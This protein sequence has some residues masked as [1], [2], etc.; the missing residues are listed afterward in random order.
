[1]KS[2]KEIMEDI[3]V[4]DKVWFRERPHAGFDIYG[5]VTGTTGDCYLVRG[6]SQYFHEDNNWIVPKR[7][8]HRYEIFDLQ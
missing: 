5:V 6:S 2:G 1:M 7:D 8:V 4:G 3:I